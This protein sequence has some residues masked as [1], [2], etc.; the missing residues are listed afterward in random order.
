MEEDALQEMRL[1]VDFTADGAYML[2][3]QLTVVSSTH[4]HDYA[5]IG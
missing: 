4:L 5:N 3:C 1:E 2:D